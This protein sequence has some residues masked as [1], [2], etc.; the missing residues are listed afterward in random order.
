MIFSC[1]NLSAGYGS[2]TV[3]EN[4]SFSLKPHKITV[5]L[6]K[7][8]CGK[9][10]LVSCINQQL[11]G[12]TGKI[13]C[14]DRDVRLMPPRERARA[15][16]ILP[17]LLPSP[18]VT[19]RE[20]AAFGRNPYL[21]PGK[22]MGA[23]DREIIQQALEDTGAAAFAG[24][25]VCH[26]SGGERQKAYL[27]MVLAQNTRLVVLDEPTTY[28]DIEYQAHFLE[29][30]RQLKTKHKKTLLVVMHDLSAAMDA[31]DDA[32]ILQSGRVSFCGTVQTCLE[33]GILERE[34][35]VRQHIF[36]ENGRQFVVFDGQ[37]SP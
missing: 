29:M 27:A 37:M 10:T 21:G 9:S 23:E 20:L 36:H 33:T 14:C 32:V 3:L 11:P 12:Y 13:I 15:V 22:R 31:A 24:E 4:V 7:N 26:L 5:L 8:G 19:V 1:Q 17:Q 34:F 25:L 35:H 28:M 18:A 2:R 30:L 6:G 16:A